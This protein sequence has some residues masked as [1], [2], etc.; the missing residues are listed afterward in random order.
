MVTNDLVVNY[1]H[2][3]GEKQELMQK[4]YWTNLKQTGAAMS[5]T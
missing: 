1:K 4:K 5:K 2:K 3:Y